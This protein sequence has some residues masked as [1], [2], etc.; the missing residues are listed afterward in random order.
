MRRLGARRHNDSNEDVF[1]RDLRTG[2]VERVN[3]ASDGTQANAFTLNFSVDA[4][5]RTAVFD[6]TASDLVPMD[7]NGV[8]AVFLRRLR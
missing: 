1:V 3:V 5:G 2:V 4:A 6:S 7:A 8:S